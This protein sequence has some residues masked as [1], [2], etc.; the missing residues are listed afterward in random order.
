[1]EEIDTPPVIASGE[2]AKARDIVAAVKT[3]QAI[4]PRAT[5]GHR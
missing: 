3:L 5:P 1:M 2:K 4:E